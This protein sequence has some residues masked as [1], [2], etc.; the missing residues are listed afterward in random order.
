VVL[1]RNVVL[2]ELEVVGAPDP[3]PVSG[4]DL[5]KA[6]QDRIDQDAC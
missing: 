6:A 1:Q 3:M 4:E 2:R 5:T